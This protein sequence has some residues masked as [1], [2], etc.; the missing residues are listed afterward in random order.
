MLDFSSILSVLD[1]YARDACMSRQ[2]AQ[3]HSI[4]VHVPQMRSNSMHVQLCLLNEVHQ[5]IESSAI[6]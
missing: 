5:R 2:Y 1:A 4:R 3:K 6:T